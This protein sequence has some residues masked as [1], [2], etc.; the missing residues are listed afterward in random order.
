MAA[1]APDTARNDN[2]RFSARHH[3][4]FCGAALGAAP[5]AD[6]VFYPYGGLWREPVFIPADKR[7]KRQ[8]Q[9]P[10]KIELFGSGHNKIA[11]NGIRARIP[12]HLHL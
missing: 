3:D 12:Q 10:R 4:C 6:A 7:G 1:K 8:G 2:F 11:E 9:I 5:A